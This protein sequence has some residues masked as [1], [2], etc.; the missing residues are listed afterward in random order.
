M[1]IAASS[2]AEVLEPGLV[3]IRGA[4]DAD[5]QLEAAKLAM[6]RGNDADGG[7]FKQDGTLNCSTA[8]KRGRIFDSIDAFDARF[9]SLCAA[10][11]KA[12]RGVD[13]AMP[14][15]TPSHL[16]LVLYQS[17]R[18][19]CACRSHAHHALNARSSTRANILPLSLQAS[20]GTATTRP[21][22][23]RMTTRSSRFVWAIRAPLA[24]ATS[25]RGSAARSTAAA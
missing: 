20:S 12:A 16:L 17:G 5:A 22:T 13:T 1:A 15:M 2:S 14:E 10:A 23:A 18:G 9:I 11:V 19:A 3:L 4:L 24:C 6:A 8:C 25:G 7:F 21:T